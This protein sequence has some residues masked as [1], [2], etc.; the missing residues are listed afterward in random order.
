MHDR[1]PS[2][3]ITCRI[4]PLTLDP[5]NEVLLR[6]GVPL[7]L[8]RR[9]VSL[10]R[11]LVETPGEIVGKDALHDAAWRGQA[12]EDSNLTVQISQLRRMLRAAAADGGGWIETL[13]RRGYR[14]TGPAAWQTAMPEDTPDG[15][16]KSRAPSLA[17]PP[18]PRAV[19]DETTPTPTATV[20]VSNIPVSVPLHFTGRAAALSA[21]RAALAETAQRPAIVVLHGLRGVGKTILA[22]AYARHHETAYRATWWLRAETVPTLRADLAALAIRLGWVRPKIAEN[23]ALAAALDGLRRDGGN[24]L[25][26]YDNAIDAAAL[27]PFLPKAGAAHVVVTSTALVWRAYAIPFQLALWPASVGADYL[28]ARTGRI[29][30]RRDAETLSETLDGLPLAHEQAAAY[31]E[32]LELPIAEYLRRF[33]AAPAR[34]LDDA[35]HAPADYHGGLTVAKAFH[36]AI[37]Q[38]AALHP[39]AEALLQYAALLAPEPIPVFL[40]REGREA[41]GE[42][43][44]TH[45]AEDGLDE[46]LAVLRGFALLSREIIPD[47]QD[48]ALGTDCLRLHRL[49][50]QV[51]AAPLSPGAIARS[52][53]TLIAALVAVY[54]P[55]T[56]GTPA[57]WPRARRLD[58]LA[59]PLVA[60]PAV[61]PDGAEPAASVLLDSLASFRHGALGAFSQARPLFERAHALAEA[62]MGREHPFT[63]Q[64]LNNL[65]L[66]VLAHGDLPAARLMHAQA[67]AIRETALGPYHPN[68]AVSLNNLANVLAAQGEHASARALLERAL[69]IWEATHGEVHQQTARGMNN[70]ARL[71]HRLGD[72]AAAQALHDRALEIREAC[73]GSSHP[74]TA[75]SL[76]NLALLYFDLGFLDKA[77]ALGDRATSIAEAAL[78]ADHA[79]TAANRANLARF[80]LAHGDPAGALA[81]AQRALAALS[82]A[83]APNALATYAAAT[84][85]ADCLDALE[86]HA[87]AA[88]IRCRHMP[89]G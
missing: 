4:G 29:G 62:T 69:V 35:V 30:E 65:A 84:T 66:L 42:Q 58:A 20:A 78:G 2:E 79:D 9:A 63:A 67:L 50:R 15:R 12:V 64:T 68:T 85:T 21:L 41:F 10:L 88:E 56:Y 73:L 8:G 25:L 80:V 27:R 74:D 71:L 47:E 89:A 76:N 1:P 40:F 22:A 52:R 31:I 72:F 48:P 32:C 23:V 28:I 83:L 70:L 75:N 36:L 6:D 17:H 61:I 54:P 82:S 57:A 18:P 87:E 14:F 43:L 55:D 38:A 86:R 77:C 49:V 37:E 19:F 46:A 44:A 51:A 33:D 24:L 34:L 45:L 81:L 60:P 5:R 3:R 11:R 13:A 59:L 7:P 53:A 26:V 16:P 39:A